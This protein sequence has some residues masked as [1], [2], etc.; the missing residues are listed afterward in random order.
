MKKMICFIL[1]ILSCFLWLGLTTQAE[2]T[3][4][5]YYTYTADSNRNLIP[6][7][8]AYT[9]DKQ[10]Y[11]IN[12]QRFERLEHLFIDKDDYLYITDSKGKTEVIQTDPET[13]EVLINPITGQ[14]LRRT[15]TGKIIV[16][17]K[18]LEFVGEIYHDEFVFPKSTFVTDDSIYVVDITKTSILIFDRV[19]FL[20]NQ[21]IL[22]K[23]I[24]GKPTHPIFQDEYED[25]KRVSAGYPFRPEHI[26]V[27]KRGNIYV[28]GLDSKNGLIMLDSDG[29]FMTFFGANPLRVPILDRIRSIFLTETQEKKAQEITDKKI[30]HDIPANLAIDD[31]GYIYTVTASIATNPIKKF[32][33]SGRNYFNENMIGELNMISIW[34]GQYENVYGLSSNGYIFEYDTSGNLLFLF[35]GKDYSS[36]RVGL[37]MTPVSI[38][39]N[40]DDILFV[41]D[42]SNKLIQTYKPT[43]FT[44]M[45]HQAFKAYYKEGNYEKSRD[46][47][48]YILQYN[49]LFDYAHIGLGDAYMR[50]RNYKEAYREYYYANHYEGISDAYWGMRQQ[51]LKNN[52]N[53]ILFIIVLLV[54]LRLIFYLV[55]RRYGW[56]HKIKTFINQIRTRFR[57]VDELLYIFT[58][59]KHPFNG[60]YEI[61]RENRSSVKTA[62]I[63]YLLL[64]VLIALNYRFTNVIFVPKVGVNIAYELLVL[65]LI[66]IL[67]VVSN[68]LVCTVS[69]GEGSIK[70]VYIATSYS[71]S[72]IIIILP[73]IILLSNVLTYQEIVFYHFGYLAMIVW[74]TFLVFFMI[75]DIHNYS[76]SKTIK[77]I[78]VSFFTMLIIGLFL[79][80]V[81]ALG[82]QMLAVIK[83]IIGEVINR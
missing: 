25:G 49:S 36:N 74:C 29:N 70:N 75:K 3:N 33:V 67:W 47:W 6:T 48:Q 54:I 15:Y 68:Y 1:M 11:T 12:E 43:T 50:E 30:I 52:L 61:K 44:N 80:V 76:V 2:S 32:N 51:W 63:I 62:T 26:V 10:I 16:L 56:K 4:T 7:T 81:N 69:D 57:T 83:E 73:I 60:F 58:F 46:Y 23:K 21:E 22:L 72:P 27:D 18:N 40:S 24:I 79:Y 34:I 64:G 45:I 55:D 13:G 38:A 65:A 19:A 20:E 59:L 17:D 8:D 9:P 53:T 66:L 31:K 42:Q 28:Q 5:P 78:F 82:N 41:A 71:L 39:Q 77:V 14:P 35:G 37:L